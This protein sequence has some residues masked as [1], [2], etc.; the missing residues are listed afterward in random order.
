MQIPI[1]NGIYTNTVSEFRTSYP[2]NMVPVPKVTGVSQGFLKPAEGITSVASLPGIGRGAMEWKGTLYAVAGGSLVSVASNGTVA[3]LGALPGSNPVVMD[4]SFDHLGIVTGTDLYLYDGS[5]LALVT[6]PDLGT[7]L[8]AVWVDGYWMTTD[9]TNLVVTELDDPFS[10]DPLR[11]GSSEANPDAVMRLLKIR[12]EVYAVNRHTIEVFDNVGGTGFPFQRIE[13]AQM[14]KGAVGNRAACV[15]EEAVAMLGGGVNEQPAVWLGVNGQVEKI[16]TREIDQVLAGHSAT[17]LAAV[18][19]RE[20]LFNSHAHL[21]VTL[22]DQTLVYDGAASREV[23]AP[24]WFSLTTSVNGLG[25]YRGGY[26]THAYGKWWVL[27]TAGS[28]VGNLSDTESDHWG[29]ETGWEFGTTVLYN[30]GRGA[31]VHELELVA[32]PG[33]VTAGDDP[34]I[35]MQHS[36][37]GMD[38]SPERPTKAGKAGETRK[39]IAWRQVG[40]MEQMRYHRFRGAGSC[41]VAIARLEAQMEGLNH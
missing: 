35:W 20:R 29:V 13:G 25:Q 3:T 15:Y 39:R 2:R 16:S 7:V 5:T 38:W 40:R 30:E 36:N 10:V 12:N 37:N 26:P 34:T 14:Q 11:Y 31:I 8:D 27:D 41:R 1:I 23:G 28:A 22:P 32:V 6:D 9:G 21:Y 19:L 33:R 17:T 4:Y 18:E 24:V